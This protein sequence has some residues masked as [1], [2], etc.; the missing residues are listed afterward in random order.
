M[1]T[2]N[3]PKHLVYIWKDQSKLSSFLIIIKVALYTKGSK[4]D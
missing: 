2:W 3:I 4:I 1:K